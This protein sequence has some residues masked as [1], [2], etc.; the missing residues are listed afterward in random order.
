MKKRSIAAVVLLP[1]VTLG[2]YTIYW[3][4]STKGELNTKGA[5]IPTAWL[6]IIPLV[7]IWWMWKYYEGAEQVTNSKVNGVLM[8][9]LGVFITSLISTALCQDAYNN[10]SNDSVPQEPTVPAEPVATN[11]S[12]LP[13]TQEVNSSADQSEPIKTI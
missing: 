11:D 8:F 3:F 9:V 4:V 13:V 5:K 7:N 1:F 12:T 2:I 6:I 10:L